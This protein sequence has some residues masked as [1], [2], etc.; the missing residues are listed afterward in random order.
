VRGPSSIQ[1]SLALIRRRLR[2]QVRCDQLRIALV[3]ALGKIEIR[4]RRTQLRLRR[5]NHGARLQIAARIEKSR[6]RA[7]H[8]RDDCSRRHFIA[9]LHFHA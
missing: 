2:N 1:A 3:L 4:L 9:R 7:R 6:R 8:P 5:S